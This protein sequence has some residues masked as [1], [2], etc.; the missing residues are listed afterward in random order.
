MNEFKEGKD[1]GGQ[2]RT[3]RGLKYSL[4]DRDERGE[5]GPRILSALLPEPQ[6][7]NSDTRF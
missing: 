6:P 1:R 7:A 3:C 4:A 5:A 2:R